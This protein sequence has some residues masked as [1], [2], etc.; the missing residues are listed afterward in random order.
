MPVDLTPEANPID[1]STCLVTGA[2]GY[3]GSRLVRSLLERGCTVH[4]LDRK[5]APFDHSRLTWFVGD[6]RR[7]ADLRGACEGVGTIFHTAALIETVERAPEAFA[8]IVWEVNVAG[9]ER[10][11]EVAVDSGVERLVHT[12]SIVAAWGQDARGADESLPYSARKDLYSSTK[13]AAERLVLRTNGRAG[14]LTCAVRPGGIYGPGERNLMVGPMVEALRRGIPVITFGDGKA[15][16]DYT[17]IDNVVDAQ[18]RAAERLVEGS[19]V[20]GEAYF[21]TDDAPI[22]TGAFSVQL[23]EAMG[24]EARKLRIPGGL[25]AAMAAIGERVFRL[26]GKPKPPFSVL[27]VRMSQVNA[28]FSIDKARRHLGY[29]PLVDTREGLRRTALDARAYYDSLGTGVNEPT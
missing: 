16:I 18:V 25:A 1:G 13:V 2:A 27:A 20:C 9:T 29:E 6:I 17:Y 28:Y 12:S 23:V 24:I 15:R 21:V 4:G 5:P 11:L 10:L 22:N 26:F 7:D 8:E 19:P 3:L 14:L